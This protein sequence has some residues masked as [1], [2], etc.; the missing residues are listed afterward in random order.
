MTCGG[1][2]RQREVSCVRFE[3]YYLDMNNKTQANLTVLND[4]ECDPDDRPAE[5]EECNDFPCFFRWQVGN[6]RGVST[7]FIHHL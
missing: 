7:T 5:T 2:I 6:F 1:G 3:N 4:T